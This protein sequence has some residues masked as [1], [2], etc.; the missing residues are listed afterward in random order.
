MVITAVIL[1]VS[2]VGFGVLFF[3]LHNLPE[4]M[5]HGA[6]KLQLE[7][8]SVLCLIGLLTHIHAFWIVALLLAMIDIP[9]FGGWLGR[10]TGAVE[11]IAGIEPG[12]GTTAEATPPKTI[13]DAKQPE[14]AAAPPP[15]TRGRPA[16]QR[17]ASHA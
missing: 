10:I 1:M 15:E 3:R 6:G 9:D 5:A 11:K 12:E 13:V 4:H 14:P 8:V 7:I 16:R 2:I 17:E